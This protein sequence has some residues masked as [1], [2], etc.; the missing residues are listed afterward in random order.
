VPANS[1]SPDDPSIAAALSRVSDEVRSRS[2][3]RGVDADEAR[4]LRLEAREQ[5]ERYW[6]VSAERELMR[7]PGAAGRFR[8][9]LTAPVKVTVRRLLRWYVEPALT[10]QRHFNAAILR[11]LDDLAERTAA[12]EER[13]NS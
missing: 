6:A 3:S 7:A 12:L 10:E 9:F 1:S 2:P 8:G 11:I 4:T 5:A 13:N